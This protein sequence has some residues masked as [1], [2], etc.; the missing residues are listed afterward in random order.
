MIITNAFSIQMLSGT[1]A[2]V[3]FHKMSPSQL[4]E[5]KRDLKGDTVESYI[6][7]PDTAAVVSDVLGV[8]VPCRR[9]FLKVQ[10]GQFIL[11]AQLSGGRLP[12]GST[13]LPDGFKI[14]FW[15]A[16]VE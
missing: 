16:H 3:E 8:E 12:E 5:V 10:T 2:N 6:G 11:I 1:D 4:E 7:H 13:R 9:G 14:E 15:V